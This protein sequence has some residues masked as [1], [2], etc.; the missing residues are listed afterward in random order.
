MNAKDNIKVSI[1]AYLQSLGFNP[2]RITDRTEFYRMPNRNE[3]TPSMKVDKVLNLW[4]DFGSNQGGSI[5]DLVMILH[6]CT[7]IEAINKLKSSD[8][9]HVQS[10]TAQHTTHESI[11]EIKHIQAL[12]NKALIQYLQSRKIY[13]AFTASFLSEAYYKLN[14]KQFFAIAF[15]NDKN[16]YELRNQYW[17][18][19]TSPKYYSSIPG[20]K[21]DT[22]NVFE[23]FSDFLS[24][25]VY[26]KAK[27]L[28]ND[29]I[30]LNSVI[31]LKYAMQTICS[32][33]H[34]NLFLDNDP[35]GIEASNE[36]QKKCSHALNMA[37]KVY[38]GHKD[39]NEYLI[40]L[41]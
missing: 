28:K 13:N 27:E 29:T 19:S 15:R 4:Y 6:S 12:Q 30:V 25:I 16:G 11:I 21:H 9:S 22:V 31:N 2:D 17:K 36:I 24:A 1:S 20:L 39:F 32:Y 10:S 3:R 18:G 8:F 40:A 38:P 7:F 41:A 26:Y 33:T 14:G 5:V 34:V 37:A 23:G 35:T